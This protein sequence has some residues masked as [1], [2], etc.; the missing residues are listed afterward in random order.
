MDVLSKLFNPSVNQA[1]PVQED[2]E[3]VVKVDEKGI[4]L[5]VGTSLEISSALFD[6]LHRQYGFRYFDDR[7]YAGP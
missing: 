3:R 2:F 7:R 5:T 4:L 1:S 6:Y